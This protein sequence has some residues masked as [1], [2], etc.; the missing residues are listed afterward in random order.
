MSCSLAK[1]QSGTSK[2]TKTKV[3]VLPVIVAW[4]WRDLLALTLFFSV[5]LIWKEFSARSSCTSA[6]DISLEH[7]CLLNIQSKKT[8][9]YE[10]MMRRFFVCHSSPSMQQVRNNNVRIRLS[11]RILS[12]STR[13]LIFNELFF[14]FC[15]FCSIVIWSFAEKRPTERHQSWICRFLSPM[16]FRK[17]WNSP[18]VL[19]MYSMISARRCGSRTC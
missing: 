8:L 16:S 19:D 7:Q 5:I 12:V 6:S 18:T 2:R 1:D 15:L 4:R 9:R 10:K 13:F 14:V 3:C 11:S 17:Q